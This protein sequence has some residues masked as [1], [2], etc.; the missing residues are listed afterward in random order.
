MG[1]RPPEKNLTETTPLIPFLRPVLLLIMYIVSMVGFLQNNSEIMTNHVEAH[2]MSRIQYQNT[3]QFEVPTDGLSGTTSMG[4]NYS[5]HHL[6]QLCHNSGYS[7]PIHR[8]VCAIK[9]FVVEDSYFSGTMFTIP[10]SNFSLQDINIFIRSGGKVHKIQ[11][12]TNSSISTIIW[13]RSPPRYSSG[14][15]QIPAGNETAV[16]FPAWGPHWAG[17]R[18]EGSWENYTTA[19][20]VNQQVCFWPKVPELAVGETNAS[21]LLKKDAVVVKK[22]VVSGGFFENFWHAM[23]IL[24]EWCQVKNQEDISFLV[25]SQSPQATIPQHVSLWANAIGIDD[26]RIILHDRPVVVD[27]H[28]IYAVKFVDFAVDWSCLHGTLREGVDVKQ[29]IALVYQRVGGDKERDIPSNLHLELVDSLSQALG[30]PVKTFNG[31]ETF[32]E[33][34]QLFQSAKIVIGPH[35]AGMANLVFCESSTPVVELITPNVTRPWQA[36]GGQ[37]ILLPWWPVMVSSF[38]DRDGIMRAVLV[39]QEALFYHSNVQ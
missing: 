5:S 24:N 30:I 29:S 10:E 13:H 4:G 39:A 21:F 19:L 11:K 31:S 25:Q 36:F 6:L 27:S 3:E 16:L 7:C 9:P 1:Q 22:V 38:D 28:H 37:S 20:L 17:S 35:G 2:Q 18:K 15:F 14:I 32:E 34:R 26:K 12:E 33:T 8:E 23:F